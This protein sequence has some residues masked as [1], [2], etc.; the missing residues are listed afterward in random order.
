[1]IP[2]AALTSPKCR[3]F[4]ARPDRGRDFV[5][6]GFFAVFHSAPDPFFSSAGQLDPCHGRAKISL[7]GWAP[8]Y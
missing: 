3:P 2:A 7:D 4:P 5:R 6:R 8:S 1:M